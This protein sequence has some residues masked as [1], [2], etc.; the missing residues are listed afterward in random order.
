MVENLKPLAILAWVL[1]Y[2]KWKLLGLRLPPPGRDIPRIW[3][4]ARIVHPERITLAPLVQLRPYS[5]VRGV[6]GRITIGAHTGIGDYTIINAVESIEIG[7]R[8][9][10][11][12]HCHV[13]DADHD[14]DGREPMQTQGRTARPVVIEDEAWIASGV[15]ITSGVRIGRGAVVGAGAVVTRSVEPFAIVA[16]VPARQIG[17]R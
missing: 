6:P 10:I 17:S 2:A 15:T 13:T 16:G 5:V 1:N 4:G 12:S 11:A 7:S 9:M 3:K 8:V 14:M